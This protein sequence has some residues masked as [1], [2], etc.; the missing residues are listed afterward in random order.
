MG[1]VGEGSRLLFIL[2]RLRDFVYLGQIALSLLIR[3]QEADCFSTPLS[4]TSTFT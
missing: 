1:S 2:F 4:V 3:R